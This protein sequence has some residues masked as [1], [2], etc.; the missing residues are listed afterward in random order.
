MSARVPLHL[1]W[2]NVTIGLPRF[3]TYHSNTNDCI[4][5]YFNII[6]NSTS[7]S[8][9]SYIVETHQL[10]KHYGK[11]LFLFERIFTTL[12]KNPWLEDIFYFYCFGAMA[13]DHVLIIN[14]TN[15]LY[16]E[17]HFTVKTRK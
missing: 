4:G 7:M 11:L 6:S 12:T 5:E 16:E 14:A 8:L 2:V 13:R 3:L 15:C 17:Y 10:Y 9:V 1:P